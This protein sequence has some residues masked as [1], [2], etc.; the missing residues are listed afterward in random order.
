MSG[1]DLLYRPGL[2]GE[3]H[4]A[5]G[6]EVLARTHLGSLSVDL[7]LSTG[8]SFISVRRLES[9][10]STSIDRIDASVFVAIA[11]AIVSLEQP[12]VTSA[13]ILM[14]VM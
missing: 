14:S 9:T 12:I 6:R 8:I 10:N 3:H 7:L 11:V 13:R 5:Q 2:A 1:R 4:V